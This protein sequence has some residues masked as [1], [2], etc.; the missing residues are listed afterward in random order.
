MHIGG[1]TMNVE[2]QDALL[3]K[4]TKIRADPNICTVMQS[5]EPEPSNSTANYNQF[6]YDDIADDQEQNEQ[7][8]TYISQTT[9][10]RKK[11]DRVSC[12]INK[13][14]QKSLILWQNFMLVQSVE[15]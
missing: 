7:F 1:E 2:Y 15:I 3:D 13:V 11:N 10:S 9:P 8:S 5:T 12:L 4:I 14:L 6:D